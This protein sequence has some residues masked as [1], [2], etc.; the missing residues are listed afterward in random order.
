MKQQTIWTAV[1]PGVDNTYKSQFVA[2]NLSGE[3]QVAGSRVVI[4]QQAKANGV[5]LVWPLEVQP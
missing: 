4:E 2:R 1:P 5:R 3:F